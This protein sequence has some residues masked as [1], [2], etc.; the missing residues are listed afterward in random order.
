MKNILES[1]IHN[2][3]IVKIKNFLN[4]NEVN[5]LKKIIKYFS[6]PKGHKYSYVSLNY[7]QLFLKVLKLNFK[8]VEHD[9]KISKFKREIMQEISD[10]YFK[11]KS[12]LRVSDAYCSPISDK[13]ILSWHT[14][15]AYSG[16]LDVEKNSLVDPN[17]FYLKFMIYLTDVGPNNGCTSYIPKSHKITYLIRKGIYERKLNYQ[18]YW[19]LKQ[20]INFIKKKENYL[21]IK[22]RLD[23]KSLID[24]FLNFKLYETGDSNTEM[25]SIYNNVDFSEEDKT[26][27]DFKLKAGDA[28][29]FDEGGVHKGSKT[30]ENERV[31]I[32][33]FYS[34]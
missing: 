18:P 17:K 2:E 12:F 24:E 8:K 6:V 32:R 11:K 4:E 30:L 29:V 31:V 10:K 16:R 28:I 13:D 9:I 15:Q 23:N 3:G 26:K 21:Y 25:N 14:D 27:Y 19:T 34:I 22:D 5:N 7:Y 33:Y 1:Q 20:L